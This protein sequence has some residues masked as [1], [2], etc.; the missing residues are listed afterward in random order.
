[1]PGDHSLLNSWAGAHLA[2]FVEGQSRLSDLIGTDPPAW[3][4]NTS[5]GLLTLNGV[6]LQCALLGSVVEGTDVWRWSWADEEV[7]PQSIAASRAESLKE[8]GEETGLWEFTEPAFPLEGIVDLGMTP[9]AT[10]A[11]V[12]SPQ[13]MGGAIFIGTSSGKKLYAVVTDPRLTME[14]P[15]AFT[16]PAHIQGAVSYGMGNDRDIVTVYASSH[17]LDV[18]DT[19]TGMRLAFEDGSALDI[20]ID[21]TGHIR[22]M[23]P[24]SQH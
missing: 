18:A 10:L 6:H 21:E 7:D 4:L 8:F 22:H 16:A 1:M 9:G 2:L 19:E 14:A 5:T 13:I 11:L 24:V 23:E 15:T 17:Q 3:E 20:L 12:A